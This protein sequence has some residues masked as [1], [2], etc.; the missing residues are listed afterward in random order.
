ML[1]VEVGG[2]LEDRKV[3]GLADLWE[4]ELE[5]T[6]HER[7]VS[8]GAD[9]E[10]QPVVLRVGDHPLSVADRVA[11]LVLL[12][13][14]DG[15]VHV[16]VSGFHP[17]HSVVPLHLDVMFC[18]R[19]GEQLLQQALSEDRDEWKRLV[20]GGQ[21]QLRPALGA[22]VEAQRAHPVGLLDDRLDHLKLSQ[23][24]HRVGVQRQPVGVSRGPPL[25]VDDQDVRSSSHQ[26]EG[27][28]Q[29]DRASPHH[30]HLRFLLPEHYGLL[31]L[32]FTTCRDGLTS[33]LAQLQRVCH[34]WPRPRSRL[35]AEE[36]AYSTCCGSYHS[37]PVRK[38]SIGTR[39]CGTVVRTVRTV[40]T[41]RH[42]R[43]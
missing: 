35:R 28:D 40:R 24:L 19:V 36:K 13:L 32:C 7:A 34:R 14:V 15:D 22:V 43:N 16:V 17:S 10:R 42:P 33:R 5:L 12:E 4:V 38:S 30:E 20:K 37:R 3:L 27:G 21:V 23:Q 1:E 29:P 25:L 11:D 6:A 8:V 41:V 39:S 31:W 26:R 2:E 9:H 18:E